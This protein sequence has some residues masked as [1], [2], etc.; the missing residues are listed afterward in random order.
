MPDEAVDSEDKLIRCA[1]FALY[2]AKRNGR[3]RVEVAEGKD[4]EASLHQE[5]P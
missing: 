4:V 5:T 1:D 2:E 3:D